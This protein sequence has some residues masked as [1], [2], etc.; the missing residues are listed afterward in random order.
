HDIG[1]LGPAR[2]LQVNAEL[3]AGRSAPDI[4]RQRGRLDPERAGLLALA[5]HVDPKAVRAPEIIRHREGE[6]GVASFVRARLRHLVRALLPAAG[7][8]AVAD[9]ARPVERIGLARL[10]ALAAHGDRLVD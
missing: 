1:R 2:A 10:E 5:T 8:D 7:A 9:H 6:L 4:E 3:G